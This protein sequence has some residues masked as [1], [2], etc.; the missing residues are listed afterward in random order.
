MNYDVRRNYRC[1]VIN[2]GV[3][4]QFRQLPTCSDGRRHASTDILAELST[5]Q[6]DKVSRL[7]NGIK[8][9]NRASLSQS[10]TLVES[11]NRNKR[12]MAKA[13]LHKLLQTT[14]QKTQTSYRIGL[15][16]PPGA[17]KSTFIENMGRDFVNYYN[18]QYFH[19]LMTSLW[20]TQR[21]RYWP[22]TFR[23]SDNSFGFSFCTIPN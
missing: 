21:H 18:F 4:R 1:N 23:N 12:A 11:K 19:Y 9:G 3:F 20:L 14:D 16:G 10:I 13:I 15:S 7:L 8:D 2:S 22:N 17:G 6:I 5:N